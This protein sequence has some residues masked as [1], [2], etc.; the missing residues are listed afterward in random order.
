MEID[1]HLWLKGFSQKSIAEHLGVSQGH[2]SEICNGKKE[3][4]Q[5]LLAPFADL[6]GEPQAKVAMA[7]ARVRIS[8]EQGLSQ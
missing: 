1:K 2:L 6:I 3:M 8:R 5:R 7:L 4:P